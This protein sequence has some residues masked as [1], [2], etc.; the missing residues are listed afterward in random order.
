[1]DAI[2]ANQSISSANTRIESRWEDRGSG[3]VREMVRILPNLMLK[4]HYWMIE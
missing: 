1:M 4:T 2:D 3:G